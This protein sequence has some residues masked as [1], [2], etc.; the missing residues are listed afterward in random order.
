MDAILK[1]NQAPSD[2]PKLPGGGA[3]PQLTPLQLPTLA[4]EVLTCSSG[5]GAVLT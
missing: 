5:L 1:P 3:Y 2:A 4:R